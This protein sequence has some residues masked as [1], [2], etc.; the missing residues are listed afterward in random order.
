MKLFFSFLL[1]L[2]CI[3]HFGCTTSS[4]NQK[5][6]DN[7]LLSLEVQITDENKNPIIDR[8]FAIYISIF[9]T[10]P[11]MKVSNG[12]FTV[13]FND[14]GRGIIEI[15]HFKIA[16]DD[17]IY[18]DR[19]ITVEG[20]RTFMNIQIPSNVLKTSIPFEYYPPEPGDVIIFQLPDGE[21]PTDTTSE[22][23]Q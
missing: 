8:T 6:S 16:E 5:T 20:T 13:N 17:K 3:G 14:P 15:H 7:K 10:E 21:T 2:L 23:E 9:G 4:E 12:K 11:W 1:I 18:L 22:H 19:A